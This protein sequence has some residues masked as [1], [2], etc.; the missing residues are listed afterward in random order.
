MA[1][2]PVNLS[3]AAAG[4]SSTP[5]PAA[6]RWTRRRRISVLRDEWLGAATPAES[7]RIA[8]ALNARAMQTMPHA[9]PGFDW[10]PGARRRDVTGVFR[11]P[12]TVFWGIGKS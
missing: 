6:M 5:P 3:N 9:P 11:A 12:G 7:T 10:R 2:L 1:A 4:R 8:A